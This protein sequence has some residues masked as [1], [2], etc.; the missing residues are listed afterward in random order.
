MQVKP[1][2]LVDGSNFLFR[3]YHSVI[4]SQ[5]TNK[6]NEPTGAT[7]IYINMLNSLKKEYKDSVIAIVFDAHAKTFRH[8]KYPEYKAIRKPMDMELR[9]QIPIIK[10]IIRAMGFM[11]FEIEGVEADDVLGSY[12][13]AAKNEGRDLIIATGDKDLCVLIDNHISIIDTMKKKVLDRDYVIE[14][15]GVEPKLISDYLALCGDSVDNIPGMRGIGQKT[16][17]LLINRY[18]TIDN[19]KANLD[20]VANINFRKSKSFKEDFLAQEEDIALYR[21]LTKIKT[22]VPLPVA[23]DELK[24]NE[25]DHKTLHDYYTRLD[26]EGLK[27]KE[28]A[29]LAKLALPLESQGSKADFSS[30]NMWS[31]YLKENASVNNEASKEIPLKRVTNKEF[32]E[33]K[34]NTLLNCQINELNTVQ[35]YHYET[36]EELANL[37]DLLLKEESYAINILV[38]KDHYL[39][40]KIVGISFL[41]LNAAGYVDFLD[42]LFLVLDKE[43]AKAKLSILEPLFLSEKVKFIYD[44]KAIM[45]TLANYGLSINPPYEDIT[46]LTHINNS[47]DSLDVKFLAQK[48]L[49]RAIKTEVDILGKGAKALGYEELPVDK[50]I[51]YQ[52][53]YVTTLYNLAKTLL[54]KVKA[55]PCAYEIYQNEELPLVKVLCAM[56]RVGVKI[57]N[58]TLEEQS[59][60]LHEQLD[61]I[62]LDIYNKAGEKFNINSPMQIAE[63]LYTKLQLPVVTK[64]AKGEPS[65]SEEALQEL[66]T[67]SPL[68]QKILEY[69]E[70]SKLL[71]TYVDKLG[72]YINQFTGRLHAKFNQCGTNTGRLSS[73]EPNLQ[74]IPIRTAEGKAVRKAFDARKGYKIVAADYS[75]IELRIMAHIAHV[76]NMFKAFKERLDIHKNTASEMFNIPL[77]KVDASERRKAKAINF[78][79]IYGMSNHGLAKQI[80]VSRDIAKDYIQAYFAKYPEVNIYMK[81]VVEFAKEHSYVTTFNGKRIDFSGFKY[82]K[83]PKKVALQR[84]AINAPIQGTA[85][86]II[87]L[88]M[89]KIYDYIKDKPE[90]AQLLM[91]VHDELVFEI[92]EDKVLEYKKIINDIMVGV[93]N[94]SVPLEVE[95][96]VGDNWSEAH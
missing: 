45:H 20:D 7:K 80:G 37:K 50:V 53:E 11:I 78:G 2:I 87:K 38:T 66:V 88:A 86:Q 32:C 69:R 28:E 49:D 62:V 54:A 1:I 18:G 43:Q 4:N 6:R 94:L 46:L 71:N 90:E 8:E 30:F 5:L 41:G 76:T 85:A 10:G 63:L 14:K 19:I 3:A 13:Q 84:A 79:L 25:P 21:F 67:Y 26:F 73:S 68:P 89:I 82:E 36:S 23:L 29:M 95:V 92:R 44:L 64:T 24:F 72:N 93:V 39:E 75:Q 34:E 77:D 40:S 9:V 58:Q 42:P 16:A 22:D 61:A 65:T 70:L 81:E 57:N 91:Q 52:S 56:E 15:F 47:D 35:L 12:A 74:N 55:T 27:Q 17:Q 33:I 60:K 48:Y 31:D 96:G 83:G 51:V 59:S